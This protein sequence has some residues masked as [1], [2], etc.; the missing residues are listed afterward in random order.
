VWW[1]QIKFFVL[2]Q[3]WWLNNLKIN[4]SLFFFKFD[5]FVYFLY[6]DFWKNNNIKMLKTS[7]RQEHIFK[8]FLLVFLRSPFSHVPLITQ[9]FLA[10]F[11][12]FFFLVNSLKRC[13]E[14]LPTHLAKEW[15]T[16]DSIF[17]LCQCDWLLSWFLLN[18]SNWRPPLLFI[19]LF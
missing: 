18:E 1:N 9:Q 16:V 14:S 8:V 10:V 11:Y 4:E 13:H 17:F 3:I 7:K 5:S 6:F 15:P 19:Y 12:F 2:K